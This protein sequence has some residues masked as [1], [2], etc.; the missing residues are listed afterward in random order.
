MMPAALFDGDSDDVF[1]VAICAVA[2][3]SA[4]AKNAKCF[5]RADGSYTC[6]YA[7][8]NSTGDLD[9]SGRGWGQNVPFCEMI[10]TQRG[11]ES[12]NFSTTNGRAQDDIPGMFVRL[13]KPHSECWFNSSANFKICA[14]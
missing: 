2:P 13:P 8:L 12:A 9:I 6:T 14:K 5:T 10:V 7:A 4:F 3:A 11:I 1:A